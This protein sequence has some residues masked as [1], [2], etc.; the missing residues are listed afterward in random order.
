MSPRFLSAIFVIL[1]LM[2]GSESAWCL[3]QKKAKEGS[4]YLSPTVG[5]Y[6]FDRPRGVSHETLFGL[7]FGYD[8]QGHGIVD[9]LGVEGFVAKTQ[10]QS[11]SSAEDSTVYHFRLDSIHPL[12][13]K[14]KLVPF[15]AL[16]AGWS[17]VDGDLIA[18]DGVVVALGFGAKYHITNYLLLRADYRNMIWFSP[19]QDNYLESSIG[20]TYVFG[21]ER[22]KKPEP[23]PDED[24][25]GVEDSR[26]KCP[27][28]PHGLKVDK[29]GC[30]TDTTDSD[31][32]KVPDYRDECSDTPEGTVVDDAGCPQ[33]SDGDKIPDFLDRCPGTPA[34]VETDSNGCVTRTPPIMPL[35]LPGIDDFPVPSE[36]FVVTHEVIASSD[37]E[38][39]SNIDIP[40][41]ALTVPVVAMTAVAVP[42]PL[43]SEDSATEMEHFSDTAFETVSIDVEFAFGRADILENSTEILDRTI[44]R[45]KVSEARK[46]IVAGYT[47]SIGS[48]SANYRLSM[49]RAE[50]V[51]EYMLKMGVDPS[52]ISV[53]GYGE[54]WPVASN[55]TAAGRQKNR[56]VMIYF[57]Q[58][59]E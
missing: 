40:F 30:P 14:K 41:A 55:D 20:L 3:K 13:T 32:D 48:V 17:Y 2:M 37:Q 1:L 21:Q 50:S 4:F 33:D 28:T 5:R 7:K 23:P 25:D 26:D 29:R 45:L 39:S 9:S 58:R 12:L 43:V 56:R 34:G 15:L 8:F 35:P 44:A 27:D 22:I 36:N 51:K 19:G 42:S 47:D 59:S 16:G 6:D 31:G 52:L 57:M 46:V 24:R 18:D 38:A 11:D 53:V 49:Q 54:S 10:V